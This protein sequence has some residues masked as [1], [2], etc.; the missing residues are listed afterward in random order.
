MAYTHTIN[1]KKYLRF[2]TYKHFQTN[3]N[4][5]WWMTK[6]FVQEDKMITQL[7]GIHTFNALDGLDTPLQQSCKLQ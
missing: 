5:L 1:V 3:I 4:E 7:N 2:Y 6:Y